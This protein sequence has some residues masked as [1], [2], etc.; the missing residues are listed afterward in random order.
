MKNSSLIK[1]AE[2]ELLNKWVSEAVGGKVRYDLL[3]K[4]SR[5]GFKASTFHTK[6]N[7]KGATLTVIMSEH[8][9]LFG[10]Y[11]SESWGF[12]GSGGAYKYDPTAF[13]YS[14]THKTKCSKQKN[15]SYSIY[16]DSTYGPIFGGGSDI[17][18]CDN[19]NTNNSSYCDA[20]YMEILH[21]SCHLVQERR[22]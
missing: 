2:A 12:G 16:D 5:D 4:G 20:K 19:C 10:G 14:L 1:E 6:C 11:T 21:M 15:T 13:V 17:C 18:I 22:T 9:K 7:G 3:W 8:D